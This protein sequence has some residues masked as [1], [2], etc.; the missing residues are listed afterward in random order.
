MTDGLGIG[1]SV[2][3]LVGTLEIQAIYELSSTL[4]RIAASFYA[5]VG[6]NEPVREWL[7]ALPDDD[8]RAID[9]DIATDEFGWPERMPLCRSLG[10]GL[11]EV[12]CSISD[13]RIARVIF[14]MSSDRMVFLDGFIKKTQKIPKSELLLAQRRW[15]EV[16]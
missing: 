14:A 12:W 1:L 10:N 7:K 6:G 16:E 2:A 4:K 11:W 5:T 3:Y 13:K 8:R 9:E 15:K